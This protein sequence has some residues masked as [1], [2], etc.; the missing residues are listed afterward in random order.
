MTTKPHVNENEIRVVGMSRSGNHAI[1]NWILQGIR[2]PYCFLNCAEAGHN[3]FAWAR[4]LKPGQN[5]T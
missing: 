5:G 4:P 3:P 2:G 1:I